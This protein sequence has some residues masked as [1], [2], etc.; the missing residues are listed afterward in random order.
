MGKCEFDCFKRDNSFNEI[1]VRETNFQLSLENI[2]H[3]N[4][5]WFSD[6]SLV[7]DSQHIREWSLLTDCSLYFLW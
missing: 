2:T 6:K 5:G 1:I 4:I 3:S 7:G